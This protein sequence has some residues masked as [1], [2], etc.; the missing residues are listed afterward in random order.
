[1]SPTAQQ[2]T[3]SVPG[4]SCAHCRAAISAKV[5]QVC[6]VSAVEIDLESKQV[7]VTGADLD[8]AAIRAAIDEAGY[9]VATPSSDA[10]RRTLIPFI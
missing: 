3:Y 6:G 2:L 8:G 5:E 10:S 7:A 1:M 9:E 4:M